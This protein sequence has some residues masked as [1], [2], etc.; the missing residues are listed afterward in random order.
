LSLGQWQI[1]RIE[2]LSPIQQ[3]AVRFQRQ[4]GVGPLE[5]GWW[6]KRGEQRRRRR[7][8]KEEGRRR[9]KKEEEEGRSKKKEERRVNKG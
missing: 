2:Y 8:K 6:L 7:R 5:V 4:T 1:S 3:V 9:R